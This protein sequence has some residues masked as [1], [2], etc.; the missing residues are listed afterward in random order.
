MLLFTRSINGLWAGRDI[1]A[2]PLSGERKPYTVVQT[3]YEEEEAVFSPDG[4][5][6]AYQSNDLDDWQVYV[7][8]FPAKGQP[9]RI[10]NTSGYAAAWSADGKTILYLSDGKVISVAMTFV[11]GDLR[12]STPRVLFTPAGL[13]GDAP[14]L[15]LDPKSPR[16]ILSAR[17]R[18]IA[19]AAPPITVLRGWLTR[20]TGASARD[21]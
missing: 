3:K 12:P 8:S 6:I 21:R 10:S 1:W 11:G 4:A 14:S 2:L 7:Q 5:W 18:E 13:G 9:V 19:D 16:L 20:A 15:D 17:E